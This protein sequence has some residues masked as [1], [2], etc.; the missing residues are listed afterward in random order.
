MNSSGNWSDPTS[1]GNLAAAIGVGGFFG[2]LILVAVC[3]FV[4]YVLRRLFGPGGPVEVV[5][6]RLIAFLDSLEKNSA[7]TQQTLQAHLVSCNQ[8]HAPGGPCN[9]EDFRVAG[10]AF[11]E[12][13]RKLAADLGADVAPQA[14][15]VHAALTH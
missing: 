1:W 5:V 9:V 4:A 3:L 6:R 10:H 11:A 12:M 7:V 14:D 2:A 15:R 13:G 8:I